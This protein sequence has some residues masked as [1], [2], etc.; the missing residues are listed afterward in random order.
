MPR[1]ALYSHAMLPSSIQR[2]DHL[3]LRTDP[4]GKLIEL[5][6]PSIP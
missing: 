6:G 3:C 1:V 5:K 2:I 4:D